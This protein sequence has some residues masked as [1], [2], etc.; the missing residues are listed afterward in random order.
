MSRDRE[1]ITIGVFYDA[2]TST[3]KHQSAHEI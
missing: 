1:H 3:P 2:R